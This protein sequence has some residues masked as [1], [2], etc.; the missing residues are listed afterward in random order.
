M[1]QVLELPIFQ[2]NLDILKTGPK[3][4]RRNPALIPVVSLLE[5]LAEVVEQ[6]LVLDVVRGELLLDE[7]LELLESDVFR[8]VAVYGEELLAD[9]VIGNTDPQ[10]LKNRAKLDKVN[11]PVI[12]RIHFLKQVPTGLIHF[13][14]VLERR[15]FPLFIRV[16]DPEKLV[17]GDRPTA[18]N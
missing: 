18:G 1:H 11:R 10:L 14:I 17:S 13:V 4:P 2:L 6:V 5:L 16:K 8:H 3:L 7:L 9:G 15:E 12:V